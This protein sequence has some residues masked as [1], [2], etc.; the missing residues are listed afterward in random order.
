[1]K[2]T[3]DYRI[4][5]H[6]VDLNR[7]ASASAIMRYMQDTANLHME[8]TRPSYDELFDSGYAFILS[9]FSMFVYAPL[10]SHELIQAQS[11]ACDSRGVSHNRCYRIIRGGQT[12]AEAF[13]VW[14]L[15]DTA[16]GKLMRVGEIDLNYGS[17]EALELDLPPRFRIPSEA[18]LTLV[19]ERMTEYA[20]VDMNRHM[21]NTCYP[22]VLCGYIPDMDG[23]R[24]ASLT[25]SFVG[26]APLGE[27]LLIHM[28]KH[29]GAYYFRT[30]RE[31]GKVN[32]EARIA[33]EDM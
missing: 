16:T 10:H 6:D 8:G 25:L 32:V 26:E 5:S 13:S 2:W 7:T 19:G 33:L 29:D 31:D 12:V 9:R 17:D 11:W 28:G 4:N 24:V 27:K 30:L 1:M 14:A 15:V 18:E 21:N 20:D 3:E 22:D 23:R